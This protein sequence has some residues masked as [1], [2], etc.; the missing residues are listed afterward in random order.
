MW[1]RTA[2]EDRIRWLRDYRSTYLE[3]DIAD[4]GQVADPDA[5]VFSRMVMHGTPR[6]V[7]SSCS[8]PES[9]STSAA[10][11]TAYSMSRYPI[12]TFRPR[13]LR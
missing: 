4:A 7:V 10:P 13:P 1:H 5:F 8:P 11:F 12:E 3:R 9:V 2:R 6:T